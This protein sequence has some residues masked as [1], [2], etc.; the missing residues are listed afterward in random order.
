[1]VKIPEQISDDTKGA[2]QEQD[3]DL[4]DVP[5]EGLTEEESY[6]FKFSSKVEKCSRKFRII[7]LYLDGNLTF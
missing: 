5:P 1:M 3:A 6:D 4:A 7:I 2:K